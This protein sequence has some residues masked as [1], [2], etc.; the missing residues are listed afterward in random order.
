MAWMV[1]LEYDSEMLG[2]LLDIAELLEVCY[3]SY[4]H[5]PALIYFQ[6]H[7]GIAMANAFQNMLKQSGL[8]KK[9]LAI[10]A[11]NASSNNTQTTKLNKMGNSFD[12]ENRV[13]C[14]NHTLQLSAKSLLKPFNTTL[15]QKATDDNN[16]DDDLTAQDHDANQV[17][18]AADEEEDGGDEEEADLEDDIDD[19]HDKL[20]ALS[21][22][23]QKQVLEDTAV[24]CE[25]V[26]KVSHLKA[27]IHIT[28]S[29]LF[30]DMT[31]FICNYPFNYNRPPSLASHLP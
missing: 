26:T 18:L 12:E 5:L 6:S 14:F 2:F 15:S 8:T 4:K 27:R 17:I 23:Q 11:D 22:D 31:T 7:T 25:T 1:H 20:Q 21:E 24:V 19:E 3:L 30:T 16:D 10:N 9:I 28:N 29:D 13:C